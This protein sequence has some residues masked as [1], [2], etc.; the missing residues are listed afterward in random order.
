MPKGLVLG[1]TW[2][3][4]AHLDAVP[5]KQAEDECAA[6]GKW[7]RHHADHGCTDPTLLVQCQEYQVPKPTPGIFCAFVPSAVELL[8]KESDATPERREKELKRGVT[9]VTVPDDDRDHQGSV[10]DKG[11]EDSQPELPGMPS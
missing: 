6:C 3:L 2:V 7:K 4:L 1:E 5:A 11:D 8:L 10:W 9:V